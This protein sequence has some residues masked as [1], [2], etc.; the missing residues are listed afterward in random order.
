MKILIDMNL[1]PL[2]ATELE[3]AGIHAVHWS[4]TGKANAPD[5]EILEWARKN[6]YVLFTHDLDFGILLAANKT[7]CPS[8]IQ[9][10]TQDIT[11]AV[12][13]TTFISALTKFADHIEKGALITIDKNK[14]RV[15]ILPI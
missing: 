5:K 3:K 12:L 13:L 2:W 8:V 11:P 10:R 4:Q 14:A 9:V 6:D 1:S 15:R 7:I